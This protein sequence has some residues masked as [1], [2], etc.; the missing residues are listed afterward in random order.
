MPMSIRFYFNA[1]HVARSIHQHIY[2]L[3]LRLG[4]FKK[5]FIE[6]H[7]AWMRRGSEIGWSGS[8]INTSQSRFWLAYMMAIAIFMIEYGCTHQTP[9]QVT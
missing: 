3:T 9:V 1:F 4:L 8:Q 6:N 2:E 5:L 7:V